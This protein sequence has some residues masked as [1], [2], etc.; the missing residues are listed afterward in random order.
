MDATEACLNQLGLREK[1]QTAYLALLE[2]GSASPADIAL[3]T[4]LKRPTVY[5]LLEEL[6][7]RGFITC[8]EESG[9][10]TYHAKPPR[11]LLDLLRKQER[12]LKA[13]LPELGALFSKSGKRPVIFFRE[14]R[15]GFQEV[16][17]RL[18]KCKDKEYRYIGVADDFIETLGETFLADYVQRRIKAGIWSNALR[19]RSREVDQEFL[20]GDSKNLRRL[21]Y[22]NRPP[23]DNIASLYLFDNQIAVCSS[24]AE[25]YTLII[26]SAEL[27][28]LMRYMWEMLWQSAEK[29]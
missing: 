3:R 15:D 16:H 2:L 28:C 4:R 17:E 14:G 7:T 19:I 21:R 13:A 23:L 18:L 26:E 12:Q 1:Q 10:K 11:D 24:T 8:F 20:S 6:E 25:S 22:L 9:R 27:N 29:H 5:G